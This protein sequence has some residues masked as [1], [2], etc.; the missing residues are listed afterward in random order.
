VKILH[1]GCG[2]RKVSAIELAQYVGLAMDGLES[3]EVIHL[4]AREDL[5]PDVV[6]V[7]GEEPL[8]FEDDAFDLVIAWHVLEHIGR[9]GINAGW[10][11]GT[12]ADF[13]PELY[14]VL[15]PKGWL[16][17]ESPYRGSR[18]EWADPT[19]TRS[20]SEDAII[21]AMQDSYRYKGSMISPFRPLC[22]FKWFGMGGMEKGWALVHDQQDSRNTNIRFALKA[23]KP[24]RPWWE[25][26]QTEQD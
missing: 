13:W 2:R 26:T 19:H 14:R 22:D 12:D 10:L 6:C 4:D 15:K 5:N 25:D 16:Y 21:Y 24:L 18:W 8:P 17:A 1:V 23:E 3:A 11:E 9:Q 7:L 20:M